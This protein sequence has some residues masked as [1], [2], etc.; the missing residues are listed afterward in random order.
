MFEE[1]TYESI[2]SKMLSDTPDGIST[3]EGSLL[4]N[5]CAKQAARLEEAYQQLYFLERNM[6]T[7]TADLEHLIMDGNERGVPIGQATYAEFRAQFNC[8]MA[9]GDVLTHD[10]FNYTVFTC[11]DEE[12]HIYLIGCN[13]EGA[14][15]NNIFCELDPV[16]YKEGYEW[17]K[18]LGLV[19]PGKDMEDEE[20]YR[21]RLLANFGAQDFAGN[22]AYYERCVMQIGG[23][24]AVKVRRRQEGEEDIRI[25]VADADFR[26]PSEELVSSIQE[27]VD[28]TGDRGGGY[29]MAPIGHKVTIL[30][31]VETIC[32]ISTTI[33]YGEGYSYEDVK[34]LIK[35]AVEDYLNSLRERWG[36]TGNTIVR[37]LQIESRIVNV[38]GIIDVEGTT[39]NGQPVNLDVGDTLPVIGGITCT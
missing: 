30:P 24:G 27:K 14:E 33:T 38:P 34:S 18:I 20:A 37:I 11:L 17:G 5:A 26:A 13:E 9:P 4:Y 10:E 12:E 7:D 23:V 8:P 36:D 19:V 31:A 28:P 22:R 35:G 15:P 32:D 16:E 6:Y 2:L 3:A 25:T 1:M 21:R 39:I 29:G